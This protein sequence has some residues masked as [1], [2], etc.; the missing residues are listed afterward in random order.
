MGNVFISHSSQ[1]TNFVNLLEAVLTYSGVSVWRSSSGLKPGM[2][3]EREIN[4]ALGE[5]ET[6][7]IV[8][9]RNAAA[10]AWVKHECRIFLDK[11]PASRT[12]PILLDATSPNDV[13]I[14][15]EKF[16]NIDFSACMLTGF[17]KLLKVFGKEFHYHD[18]RSTV[19]TD[20]RR[21]AD[22]R[23]PKNVGRRLRVGFWKAFVAATGYGEFQP[24]SL[25]QRMKFK[26]VQSLSN[27]ATRYEFRDRT[28]AAQDPEMVLKDSV[29]HVWQ[30][31]QEKETTR[32]DPVG[33]A[34]VI[35]D[36]AV[37]ICKRFEIS[38]INRRSVKDRRLHST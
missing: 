29:E 12:I 20:R 7:L 22:R 15:L 1:D 13:L 10:S 26:V 3:Y 16:Q 6:L 34:Y 14:G 19:Q 8:V 28:G 31:W 38:P 18:K 9:S 37:D 33:A 11:H 17:V 23:D 25:S 2:E 5:A 4:T 21:V 35:E 32:R 36:I 24:L 27:E 30:K